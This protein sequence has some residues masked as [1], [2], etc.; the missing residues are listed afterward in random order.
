MPVC[1]FLV[2][3]CFSVLYFYVGCVSEFVCDFDVCWEDCWVAGEGLAGLFAV[4]W[5][6]CSCCDYY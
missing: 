3:D 6:C 5:V 1:A 4:D 2:V